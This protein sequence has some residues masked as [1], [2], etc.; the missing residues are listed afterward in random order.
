MWLCL[1]WVLGVAEAR[2]LTLSEAFDVALEGF[3]LTNARCR[4]YTS[5]LR[6]FGDEQGLDLKLRER[7]GWLRRTAQG[8]RRGL[9]RLFGAGHLKMKLV[10]LTLSALLLALVTVE[11]DREIAADSVIEGTV[12]RSIVAPLAG[13]L[14]EAHARAGDRVD[15]GQ[16]LARIDDQELLLEKGKWQAERD[17][18]SKAYQEA[19]GARDRPEISAARARIAQADAE[20]R[21]VEDLLTRTALR[22]P[23]S[24]T[25]VSGDLSR[26]LGAPLERGQLLFEIVPDDSYRIGLQVDEHD[27]AGLVP[28]QAGVVR[29]AGLPD[30]PIDL[31]IERI[32]PLANADA[33]GNRFRVE[34]ALSGPPDALR[35]GMQGVAKVVTGRTSLL[36]A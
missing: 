27:I 36:Q 32:V 8:A 25:L 16:L 35:P 5:L 26:S 34:A 17:K 9:K 21:L 10:A 33:D 24:G 29:L 12:Q 15:A 30:V 3:N 13:Y 23:F 19:L 31:E 6:Y 1:L 7:R 2:D 22:A 11:T 28:G 18:H 20:L 4:D 14:M